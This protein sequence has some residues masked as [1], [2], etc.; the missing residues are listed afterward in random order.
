MSFRPGPLKAAAALAAG[1]IVVRVVYR[2]LFH[3]ADGNGTV[4]LD[5]PSLRLPPPF[6]HVVALGPATTDGLWAA[7]ISA[8]PI[9]ATILVFGVLNAALDLPRL[10]ARGA[11]R[12]PFR[13]IARM[14]SVAWATLPA[15]ADAVRAVRFARQLRGERQG[16]RI[17]SPVLERTLERATAV[18]AALELRGY[19]GRGLEGACAEPVSL[20]GATVGFGDAPV[21]RIDELVLEP[22]T[23]VV[24]SGPTGAGKSTLLRTLSGLHS[25]VDGG[26][27]SG[28]VHVVGL[29]RSAVPPRDTA[30]AVG[31]VL[32]NP[33]DA[34]ATTGVA[35]EIGLA[36][37]LRGVAPVIVGAHVAEVAGRVGI[38]AL[39]DR[40]LAGL[41]AGE[42]TLVA[43]AAAVVEQPILLVVD[44]P[45]A[46][47]DVAARARIARLLDVL[48]HEAG[49]CV[50]VAEHR[51]A[52]LAAAADRILRIADGG[53]ED[54]V[55]SVT[56]AAAEI[57]ASAARPVGSTR[58]DADLRR[59][60][61]ATGLS[62]SG[63][64]VRH[65]AATVVEDAALRLD[66]GEI[67]ALT[68]PN[69]AGKSSLLAA[70]AVPARRAAG[71]VR[72]DGAPPRGRAIALVP[73]ASDDLFLRD[74]VAL[75]CRHADRR[76][77][78]PQ[79]ATARRFAAFLGLDVGDP[80]FIRR[81]PQH[82]R[83]LSVGERR[84]L[85]IALQSAHRPRVLLVD[86]PTRGLDPEARILVAGALSAEA[87][88]GAAVLI[89][90][91]D[92]AFAGA[93]GARVIP[94]R[95]GRLREPAAAEQALGRE[96]AAPGVDATRPA[97]SARA[98]TPARPKPAAPSPAPHPAGAPRPSSRAAG[99]RRA[100]LVAANLAALAAFTWPLMASALPG[101]AYAA[102]PFIALALAPVAV[103][104]VFAALDGSVRSAHTLALLAV[105]AAIGAAIRIA[106]TGVG[107]VEALF[108]LLIL[109]GRAYGARF[110]LLLGAA[111][112]GLSAIVWGG[113]GPWLPFQMF[114]CGWVGALAGLLP[115]RIRGRAEIALLCGYGVAASYLF[116]LL[117]NLWFWPFAVGSGTGISYLPGG[118]LGENLGSFLVYSLLT[119]TAG[120]D[121]LR[122]VTTVLGLTLVGRPILAALRRA[123]PVA[124]APVTQPVVPAPRVSMGNW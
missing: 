36:L 112:V 21:L 96:P 44:E 68:G 117:M 41:S 116:G 89:A 109:A 118:S 107:G 34:F 50:V 23:L 47:L 91:H 33:R 121:T 69:G 81:L 56:A 37:E 75:E 9:A 48:A 95:A 49:V 67:A 29:D 11:R 19:G 22:G 57:R 94:I 105:L 72:V 113:V 55:A 35:D 58:R 98:R 110:G 59:I 20:R 73:D 120:W 99:L 7:A 40:P 62:V 122:A 13:G 63:V 123:K 30:R 8:V 46:D 114:A 111:A 54:A 38:T 64:T 6:A 53:L 87:D 12:G 52:D 10:L 115:R 85:A 74:R 71:D 102:V 27:L 84:C 83:D 90:T 3:G 31:V 65:G 100:A 28:G 2:V 88:A 16:A 77:G 66:A 108:V 15:L 79:D 24:V 119:S 32:Q 51:I 25:H 26:S 76:A 103:L 61:E 124:P 97:A 18:A 93:L 80:A 14:L 92:A 17:L 4:L 60:G 42:A 104:V 70:I 106:G 39:L 78:L 43:I 82:P 101:D 1:F 45:L 86:E 5:L